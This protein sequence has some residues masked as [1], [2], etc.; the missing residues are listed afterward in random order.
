V[1]ALLESQARDEDAPESDDPPDPE[2]EA[3]SLAWWA[4]FCGVPRSFLA[5]LPVSGPNGHVIFEFDDMAVVK[6]R[7]AGSKDFAWDP[8][9]SPRPALWPIPKL[10]MPPGLILVE[11][12]GEGE[13]EGD[14]TVMAFH[15]AMAAPTTTSLRSERISVPPCAAAGRVRHW[16]GTVQATKVGRPRV[17]ASRRSIAG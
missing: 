9:K 6:K 13:G 17:N 7:R 15:K 4:D 2:A 14:A 3:D 5:S 10:D 12:E 8:P 16:L 11:G 1:I